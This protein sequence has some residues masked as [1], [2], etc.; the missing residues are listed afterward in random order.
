MIY[1]ERDSLSNKKYFEKFMMGIWIMEKMT[2]DEE[3]V[4]EMDTIFN[5]GD[6]PNIYSFSS[7][8]LKVLGP[9]YTAE[10]K[11][12][13]KD[14]SQVE[15]DGKWTYG[16]KGEDTYRTKRIYQNKHFQI[17]SYYKFLW[18]DFLNDTEK[19]EEVIFRRVN[20]PTMEEL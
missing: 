9:Q 1:L 14:T 19:E 3:I 13:Y 15:L 10:Y 8:Y 7:K 5:P 6:P 18:I 17:L 2:V 20:L 11:I 12:V 4:F 16:I